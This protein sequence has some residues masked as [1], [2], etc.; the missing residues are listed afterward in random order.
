M[1]NFGINAKL[2]ID[3][4]G[5]S[6]STKLT[7]RITSI[8]GVP[9]D[10]DGNVNIVGA[11]GGAPINDVS[12]TSTTSTWSANKINTSLGSKSDTGHNHTGVYEPVISKNTGFNKNLGTT[13]GTVSEGNHTHS[14]NALTDQPTIPTQTSQL[15][16]NSGFLTSSSITGKADTTYVDNNFVK[17]LST[18]GGIKLLTQAEYD[19]LPTSKTTDNILYFIKG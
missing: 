18:I 11:G 4:D 1:A 6:V 13:A 16:N 14:Y 3:A 19:A 5:K 7:E 9:P 10:V 12:T 2:V 15:T 8:N 17:A